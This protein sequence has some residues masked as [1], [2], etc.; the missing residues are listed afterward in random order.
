M[1]QTSRFLVV[2]VLVSTAFAVLGSY[3][4][5]SIVNVQKKV[6]TRVLYY[7]VNTPVTRDDPYYEVQMRVKDTVYTAQY[8]PRHEDDSILED[9]RPE[10]KVQAR[11]EKRHLFLKRGDGN[12]LDLII[13][14]RAPAEKGKGM[15][16]AVPV[17]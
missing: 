17:K 16:D 3:V 13:V 4:D 6:N 10:T 15:T 12:D 7:I 2:S 1:K 14:K 8:T 5:G 11:V 9:Y